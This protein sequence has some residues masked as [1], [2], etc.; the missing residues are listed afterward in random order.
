VA[1]DANALNTPDATRA[2]AV[3]RLLALHDSRGINLIV[4]QGVRREL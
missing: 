3:N 2:A 1:I 4:P